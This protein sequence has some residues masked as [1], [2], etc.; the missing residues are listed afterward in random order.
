MT[1]SLKNTV[2]VTPSGYVTASHDPDGTVH[3]YSTPLGVEIEPAEAVRFA[4][5]II[6]S[7]PAKTPGGLA[8]AINAA[9]AEA[10]AVDEP[11]T[12]PADELPADDSPE[13]APA[14]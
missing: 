5:Y 10:P 9:A 13:T 2:A 7:Q 8:D 14:Q 12:P 11:N 4:E 1:I 6:A 3:I